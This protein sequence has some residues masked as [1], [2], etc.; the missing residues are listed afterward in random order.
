M[1]F[2]KSLVDPLSGSLIADNQKIPRLHKTNR[3]RMV[4]RPKQ[5]IKEFIGY[6]FICKLGP[7]ITTLHDCPVHPPLSVPQKKR[8]YRPSLFLLLR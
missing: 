5:C 6:R 8:I 2:L 3:G 7:D 4:G 1:G